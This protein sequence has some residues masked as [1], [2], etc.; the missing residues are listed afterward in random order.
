MTE[1][2]DKIFRLHESVLVDI[3]VLDYNK[4]DKEFRF[5]CELLDGSE[6]K[7][8]A[9]KT[10]GNGI[11]DCGIMLK[12][13]KP[14]WLSTIEKVEP[15]EI[16]SFIP[17]GLMGMSKNK[18]RPFVGKLG[19]PNENGVTI[20]DK[21]GKTEVFK[22]SEFKPIFYPIETISH[23]FEKYPKGLHKSPLIS[24]WLL[25]TGNDHIDW[26]LNYETETSVSFYIYDKVSGRGYDFVFFIQ[27]LLC[28]GFYNFGGQKHHFLT[29]DA[30][31]VMKVLHAFA[32]DYN[33][34]IDSGFAE[35]VFSVLKKNS[36]LKENPYKFWER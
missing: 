22:W 6:T 16:M 18:F 35:S 31:I 33:N 26:E 25:A 30:T 7:I 8:A 13:A 34:Q 1:K 9:V 2:L 36:V 32:I 15:E 3:P 21:T 12:E 5:A 24:I 29:V 27:E 28:Q 23:T 19:Y 10:E 4:G 20:T 17:Y 14:E 11:Y